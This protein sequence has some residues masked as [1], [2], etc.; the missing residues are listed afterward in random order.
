MSK[1]LG[2]TLAERLGVSEEEQLKAFSIR[3]CKDEDKPP[4]RLPR[5]R[6]SS[7]RNKPVRLL[8]SL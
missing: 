2:Q 7:A 5:P 4:T 3:F 1:D 8:G 6:S